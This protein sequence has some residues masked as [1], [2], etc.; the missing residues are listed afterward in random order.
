MQPM[1]Y[2]PDNIPPDTGIGVMVILAIVW[3][4]LGS[5]D[6]REAREARLKK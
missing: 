3:F 2:T 6:R 4:V 1:S 5:K